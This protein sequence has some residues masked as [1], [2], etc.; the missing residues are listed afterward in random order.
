MLL[1]NTKL[2]KLYIFTKLPSTYIYA[3]IS[4]Y[5]AKGCR[6]T[7]LEVN[8]TFA[9]AEQRR[10][11]SQLS[12]HKSSTTSPLPPPLKVNLCSVG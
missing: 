11:Q 8:V 4:V 3:N 5:K 2:G 9:A 10:S 6:L 7:V 1:E 12:T